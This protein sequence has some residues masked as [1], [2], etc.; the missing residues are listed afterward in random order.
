MNWPLKFKPVSRSETPFYNRL[1]LD[2]RG[3]GGPDSTIVWTS[4]IEWDSMR[5]YVDQ[6]N[7][8]S[9]TMIGSS[10]LLV[11]AVGQALA[12]HPEMNRRVVRRRVY[13]Y[14]GC[15]VCLATRVPGSNEVNIVLVNDADRKTTEDIAG[16]IW[17]SQL[18]YRRNDSPYL[19]DC[20]RIRRMPAWLFRMAYRTSQ[21]L[22][23]LIHLPVLGRMDRLRESPVLVN[24]FSHTRFPVMRGYKPSRQ[25]DES[26]PLSVTLGRPEERVVWKNGQPEPQRFAPL[27]VRA[28]HRICDGFQLSQFISTLVGLLNEPVRMQPQIFQLPSTD[29]PE[30]TDSASNSK[31]QIA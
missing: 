10:H 12:T 16:L 28:D 5:E 1:Y 31:Q 11:Q 23:R 2:A 9:R 20:E 17:R 19:R 8:N 22:D 24:D 27:C 13:E 15:H 3:Q 7:Q 29:Q 25:P 26:K 30:E 4:E 6:Y 18:A 14:D 21:W